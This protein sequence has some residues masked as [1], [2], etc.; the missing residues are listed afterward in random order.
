MGIYLY[1]L[2]LLTFGL[3]VF[4]GSI[5]E[6]PGTVQG[7]CEAQE[8]GGTLIRKNGGM[9]SNTRCLQVFDAMPFASFWAIIMIHFLLSSLMWYEG[10]TIWIPPK[11]DK[12]CLRKDHIVFSNTPSCLA[13]SDKV[14]FS[15]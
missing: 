9:V 7:Q 10:M 14:F 11:P 2:A 12:G 13:S 6:Y 15:S 8:V 3:L 1:L 4:S 5:T